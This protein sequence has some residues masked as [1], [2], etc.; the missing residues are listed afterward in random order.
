MAG[1]GTPTKRRG[2]VTLEPPLKVGHLPLTPS[3]AG[4]SSSRGPMHRLPAFQQKRRRTLVRSSSSTI[5]GA[6][7]DSLRALG[8]ALAGKNRL[9]DPEANAVL[10][11]AWV[12]QRP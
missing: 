10:T 3:C 8:I 6:R 5:V 2:M 4:F 12:V 7:S 1:S 11:K 9:F